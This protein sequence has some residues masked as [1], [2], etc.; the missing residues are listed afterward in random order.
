MK[1]YTF[2]ENICIFLFETSHSKIKKKS[3]KSPTSKSFLNVTLEF[4][5]SS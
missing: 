5:E 1:F 3:K 4:G 2:S